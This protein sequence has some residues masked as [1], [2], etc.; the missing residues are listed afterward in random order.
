MSEERSNGARRQVLYW[1]LLDRLFGLD[2]NP[3]L[4]QIT[5]QT[6]AEIGLPEVLLDDRL[7]IDNVCQRYPALKREFETVMPREDM[8]ALDESD[9]RQLVRAAVFGKLM[10]N[11]FGNLSVGTVSAQG[12]ADWC[13]DVAWF[14]RACGVA[15]GE[16]RGN[17][18]NNE[19][20]P[21]FGEMEE[22]IV[23]RMHLREVLGDDRLAEK[24]SPNIGLVEQLL[25]DKSN[26]SG[27][28]LKN[29]KRLIRQY[30][31][32]VTELLK[33][34]V[35][36]APG[37]E[38]DR[39]VPP[40]RVF[41]NL[42]L[43][44]TIW[45][46]LINWDPQEERLYVDRLFYKQTAKKNLP[47]RLIVVVDQ[48]GSMVDSMVNCAILASI[49]AGLSHVDAHLIAYDTQALDLSA[50][51]SDPFEVLMRT[52]L[53]GGNDGPV[54]MQMALP[55]IQAPERTVMVWISDFYEFQA[56]Q[57]LFDMIK[58]VKE[59][60]VRFIPVGSVSSSGYQSVNPWFKKR[61]RDLGCPVISGNMKKLI[62]ELK[63]FLT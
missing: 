5:A 21:G 62:W 22:G 41:R 49:F 63:K 55:K 17:R 4:D 26:L 37:G 40:K 28:A 10:V 38:I 2:E 31:D 7:S 57:P 25:R 52:K 58:S 60:G 13:N 11:I 27:T 14:E 32:Q 9:E 61:L 44:R 46:N 3:G 1:N 35:E 33:T 36:Q 19:L 29:A 51:V 20:A 8:P 23:K 45:K 56:S 53:G 43:E 50:W 54:A 59:S 42:D 34:Q 15:P 6:V 24:L 16:L 39:S 30:V 18:G 47:S 48:S 12:Y